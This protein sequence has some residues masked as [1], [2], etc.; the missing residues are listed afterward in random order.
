M[1]TRRARLRNSANNSTGGLLI[2][3][4]P[5]RITAV[6][7]DQEN[8]TSDRRSRRRGDG[9]EGVVEFGS[10]YTPALT[11]WAWPSQTLHIGPMRSFA[12]AVS[13][14]IV[15]SVTMARDP[16]GRQHRLLPRGRSCQ[17]R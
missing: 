1:R 17:R 16:H 6:L 8:S 5:V 3:L 10:V 12:A 15:L 9:R 2:F 7:A 11:I 4:L 13:R 14:L